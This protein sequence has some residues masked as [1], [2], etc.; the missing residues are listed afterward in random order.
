MNITTLLLFVGASAGASLQETGQAAK[1]SFGEAAESVQAELEASLAELSALREAQA[2]ELVPLNRQLNELE[3]ELLEVRAEYQQTL[4]LLDGRSLDLSNLQTETEARQDEVGYLSNLLGEY[5]RNFEAALHIAELP[6]YAQPLD[7][8]KL[9][10]E[11]PNLDPDQVFAAQARVLGA[12]LER[13]TDA[14]GGTR[15]EGTAVDASGAVRQGTFALVGHA[16]LF[17]S[18]DGQAVGAVDQRLGSLEPAVLAFAD[19]ADVAAASELLAAGSGRMPLDATLGDA[20]RI[21]ATHETFFEHVEKGGPVMIPIF[22]FAA[23]ALLVTL[24]KWLTLALVKRPSQKQVAGVLA[25]VEQGDFG[26]ARER[27]GAIG[28]PTGQMLAAGVEHL[29]EPRELVE[30][31]MYETLLTTRLRHERFLPFISIC[32]ASAP[33]LGL[34][35]TVTGIISTFKL[36]T[37]F[38]SGDVKSLSSGISEA[39]ITTE[40]G[41]IVAIPSLLLHSFLSRKARGLTSQ[42]EVV[43]MAFL[44]QVA[45]SS[46]EAGGP[47]DSAQ[48]PSIVRAGGPHSIRPAERHGEGL[49]S[50]S[51]R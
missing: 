13:L 7:E 31:V 49:A 15:F 46:P 34:L 43:A 10:P 45:R 26:A 47:G 9:A 24:Y 21:E 19:P 36:I 17:V 48:A 30:E 18:A 2:A 20:H 39:L 23:A 14:L 8:A 32:A 6:R 29:S 40:F 22:A 51:K 42:M 25:A 1:P 27:A 50:V 35:G 33:L 28:G 5:V 38:G 4:R 37:V 44:N 41:L 3:T 11:N 16:G 12:S